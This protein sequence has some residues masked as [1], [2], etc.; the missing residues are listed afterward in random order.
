MQ[1]LLVALSAAAGLIAGQVAPTPAEAPATAAQM[2]AHRAE[3]IAK[4]PV[5]RDV[6]DAEASRL[7]IHVTRWGNSGPRVVIIHGGVQ[8]G[9]GGGPT[10]FA[11]QQPWGSDGWRVEAVD[12]PGFGASPSR[13]VDDMTRDSVW[14]ADMLDGGANLIGH[15]W[16]G[17]E[18][19]LAAARRP[20]AVRSLVLVEPALTAIVAADP[21]LRN[22]P[23]VIAGDK[24]R[25]RLLMTAETPGQYGASFARMLGSAPAGGAE[26]NVA[27]NAM[28]SDPAL[29]TRTGCALLEGRIPAPAVFQ[30]A[31]ATIAEAHVPVLIVTGGW[32]PGFDA[33]A[34]VLAR[35]MH[36][37]HVI[38]RSP[39][40]F[41]QLSNSADFNREVAAFMRD[42]DR[43]RR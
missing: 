2:D 19:L 34:D 18:A 9:V 43:D 42:A 4:C 21:A 40:H 31:I 25:A 29:A 16:G 8:G 38:V 32:N 27:I 1:Q 14:I 28:T 6:P 13:G 39:N 12:R 5:M 23:A 30:N 24:M 37:R 22:N 33:A 17:A 26:T 3:L 41:V 36:G 15:S 11:K 10:T 20:A 7:P 35:L